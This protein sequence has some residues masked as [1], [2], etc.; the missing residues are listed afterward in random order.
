MGPT[1]WLELISS[2]IAP[3]PPNKE[4]VGN[5]PTIR[6]PDKSKILARE[7]AIQNSSGMESCILVFEISR[8][9][10]VLWPIH[11]GKCGPRMQDLKLA[12]VNL[13]GVFHVL[14]TN[15][16]KELLESHKTSS[17]VRFVKWSSV[18]VPCR[19]FEFN[20]NSFKFVSSRIPTGTSPNSLLSLSRS[21]DKLLKCSNR[22]GILP[23]NLLC[24][25]CNSCNSSVGNLCNSRSSMPPLIRLFDNL[26]ICSFFSF[27]KVD[28]TMPEK[29]LLSR[30][31]DW[32][33]VKFPTAAGIGPQ[34]PQLYILRILRAGRSQ[35]K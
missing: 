18:I 22:A 3:N 32:M 28:G 5:L 27:L 2:K 19:L 10:S 12:E 34:I 29:L 1:S 6:F 16:V 30:N 13:N 4:N 31:N 23:A 20:R 21:V 9:P 17:L 14:S 7:T 8:V 35:A 11:V 25:K 15:I 24:C 33:E 26:S